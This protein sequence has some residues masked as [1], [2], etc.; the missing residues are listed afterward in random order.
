MVLAHF[1]TGDEKLN[2]GRITGQALGLAGVAVMIGPGILSQFGLHDLAQL[3]V[4]AAALSYAFAGIY[5]RRFAGTP[6]L[7]TAA[8]QL[9]ASTIVILPVAVIVDAPW[10]L[11]S[12]DIGVWAAIAGLALLCTA[13]AYVIYFRILATAG[14][15]NLLLVTFLI[16]VS[17]ILLGVVFLGES[18]A[19]PQIL[20]MAMISASLAAIDGRLGAF[21]ARTLTG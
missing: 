12:P 19:A 11:P 8:G 15:T 21:V 10:R 18:L 2:A 13:L 7:V 14:A 3:G 16:P 5:G 6:P 20:G 9:C 1:L 4:L 17:A